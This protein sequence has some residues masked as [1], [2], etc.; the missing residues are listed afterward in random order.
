MK[1]PIYCFSTSRFS[2]VYIYDFIV[3]VVFISKITSSMYITLIV[4]SFINVVF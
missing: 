4:I 2:H 1:R 3:T